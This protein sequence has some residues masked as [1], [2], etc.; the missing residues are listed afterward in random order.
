MTTPIRSYRGH[1]LVAVPKML[2][3]NFF[4][5]VTLMVAH[6]EEQALGLV[7]NRPSQTTLREAWQQVESGACPADGFL[8]FGG[9][10]QQVLS[11]LHADS[12]LSNL[13]VLPGL[14]FTQEAEKL[15]LLVEQRSTPI[16]FF[17]GFAGWGAGQ[18]EAELREGAWLTGA[19]SREEVFGDPTQLWE[20]WAKRL[21][22]PRSSMLFGI[23]DPPPDPSVN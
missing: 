10:C 5:T 14:Y 13:E 22:R 20:R 18:L 19:A 4:Q 9:P 11:A 16:R 1:L 6:D 17:V 2:D 8:H 23:K 15:R 21:G 7:L 12:A 3:P